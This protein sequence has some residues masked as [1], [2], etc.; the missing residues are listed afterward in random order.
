M[1]ERDGQEVEAD[2]A[3]PR[4]KILESDEIR[5]RMKDHMEGRVR[6]RDS[7]PTKARWVEA[8]LRF[9][10]GSL[11]VK[12]E[13]LTE[14]HSHVFDKE[15]WAQKPYG[16]TVFPGESI[17]QPVGHVAKTVSDPTWTRCRRWADEVDSDDDEVPTPRWGQKVL[18]PWAETS[19][20]LPAH[21]AVEEQATNPVQPPVMAALCYSATVQVLPTDEII[22]ATPPIK[23]GDIDVSTSTLPAEM[24]TNIGSLNHPHSCG[25]ACKFARKS[26][27]CKD[28]DTCVRCHICKF[29]APRKRKAAGSNVEVS[30][31]EEVKQD[32]V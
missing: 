32:V 2:P 17:P 9:G 14:P 30:C 7:T 10:G 26:R 12:T 20:A 11:T 28:G 23:C 27:G 19:A 3:T 31:E 18:G 15:T 4:V 5:G 13:G 8:K 6:D 25:L 29:K 22:P 1:F 24:A 21:W 16:H